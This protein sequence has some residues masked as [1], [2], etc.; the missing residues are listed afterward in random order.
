MLAACKPKIDYDTELVKNGDFSEIVVGADGKADVVGWNKPEG[1]GIELGDGGKHGNVI[2][3]Y[4]ET[5]GS[6]LYFYQE[7]AVK[8]NSYYKLTYSIYTAAKNSSENATNIITGGGVGAYVG[9]REGTIARQE[10]VTSTEGYWRDFTVYFFTKGYDTL[11]VEL[12]VG[13][14]NQNVKVGKDVELKFD[15]V[16]LTRVRQSAVKDALDAG[17]VGTISKNAV[18]D[19]STGLGTFTAIFASLAAVAVCVALYYFLRRGLK[20]KDENRPAEFKKLSATTLLII[21]LSAGFVIRLLISLFIDG[22]EE[23][24]G[25]H[26]YSSLFSYLTEGF[27]NWK[28]VFYSAT[29]ST[30]TPGMLYVYALLGWV[31]ELLNLEFFSAGSAIDMVAKIPGIIADLLAAGYIF[32]FIKKLKGDKTAF[33]TAL[34][35][36]LLAPV[37]IASAGWGAD[38]SVMGLFLILMLF[39]LLDK[40]HVLTC[41]YMTLALLFNAKA[42]YVLPL[43][44]TYLGYVFYR[45]VDKRLKLAIAAGACALGF[46][47]VSFPFTNFSENPFYI[48]VQYTALTKVTIGGTLAPIFELTSLDAFN[49]YS[50][51]N[52][53]A[54]TY[55]NGQAA[56]D[57]IIAVSILVAGIALYFKKKNRADIMLIAAFTI[58]AM[59]MFTLGMQSFSMIFALALLL[60]YAVTANEK[61]VYF[62]FSAFALLTVINIAF[63]LNADGL[64]GGSLLHKPFAGTYFSLIRPGL[65]ITVSCINMLMTVYFGYVVYDITYK[66]GM[67]NILPLGD[68]SGDGLIMRRIKTLIPKKK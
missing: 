44:V 19:F 48:F 5:S 33:V 26:Y 16:G 22:H 68:D 61:R 3:M 6:Y 52:V 11:T 31:A 65:S 8:R 36:A 18:T 58:T 39:S 7:V 34:A 28:D 49:F 30:Q 66:G 21:V 27:A 63:V 15:D 37:F 9:I 62:I 32:I 53:N 12:R 35:Y 25:N 55:T 60:I 43:V 10:T 38:E 54:V 4:Q 17:T 46:W 42:I 50:M 41:V 59:F 56:L 13:N 64:I 24:V 67:K 1:K 47:V 45:D 23:T 51:I 57:I 14:E 20:D 40:K 29:G 2:T